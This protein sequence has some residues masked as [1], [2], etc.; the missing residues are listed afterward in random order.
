MTDVDRLQRAFE[1]FQQGLHRESLVE[2]NA[3]LGDERDDQRRVDL[4]EL[5]ADLHDELGDADA[6]AVDR[7][8]ANA[9]HDELH[10]PRTGQDFLLRARATRD[11]VEARRLADLGVAMEPDDPE[12]LVAR[13]NFRINRWND[14][15]GAIEDFVAALDLTTDRASVLRT[16]LR[17][18]GI[19]GDAGAACDDLDQLIDLDPNPSNYVMRGHFRAQLGRHA[20]AIADLDYAFPV[21]DPDWSNLEDLFNL[22]ASCNEALG[23]LDESR[24]DRERAA[25]HVGTGAKAA[26]VAQA[27]A[28]S[29]KK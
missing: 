25:A 19:V 6:A 14:P 8:R 26:A 15:H 4:L 10:P 16:L 20:D 21:L 9:L 7:D 11:P 1:L 27:F 5:R 2:C 3:A 18:H 17:A 23:N 29:K 28:R 22:R 24:L 12:L 13:G